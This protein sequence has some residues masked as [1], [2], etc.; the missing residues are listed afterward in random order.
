MVGSNSH[1]E[2]SPFRMLIIK[3]PPPLWMLLFIAAAFGIHRLYPWRELVDVRSALAA[4]LLIGLAIGIAVWARSLF[5]AAK[6]TLIPASPVNAALV[7][8]RPYRFSRNPMYL[9]LVMF[10]IGVSFVAGS[11]P[12]FL[13]PIA[14]FLL[15]DRVFIP[16]EEAKMLRQFGETYAVY[17][18]RVRRWL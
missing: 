7:V 2:T 10:G 18:G 8:Q 4:A 14:I 15:C 1:Q 11:I 17:T 13:A 12:M 6:T 3:I 5:V 16:F 9:A